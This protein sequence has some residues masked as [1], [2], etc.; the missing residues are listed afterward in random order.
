MDRR[1]VLAFFL[2]FLILIGSQMLMNAVYGP[3]EGGPEASLCFG[4]AEKPPGPDQGGSGEIPRGHDDSAKDP[5][6]ER[7]TGNQRR[8]QRSRQEEEPQGE[9]EQRNP[10][11]IQI[12]EDR[13]SPHCL[14]HN[15]QRPSGPVKTA[16]CPSRAGSKV[17]T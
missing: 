7:G 8:R 13:I 3:G 6:Q 11:A 10:A 14:P 5:L 1:T 9:A 16:R 15:T 2:I 12:R 4:N 17:F